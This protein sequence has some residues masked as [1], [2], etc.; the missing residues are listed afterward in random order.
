[1]FIASHFRILHTYKLFILIQMVS[2]HPFSTYPTRTQQRRGCLKLSPSTSTN[3]MRYSVERGLYSFVSRP[4]CTATDNSLTLSSWASS[5]RWAVSNYVS[6]AYFFFSDL[7]ATFCYF[8]TGA[9]GQY[10]MACRGCVP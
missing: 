3:T 7:L 9:R 10:T 1:M 2:V 6:L 5:A 4:D 8:F